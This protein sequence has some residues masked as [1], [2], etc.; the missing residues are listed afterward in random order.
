MTAQEIIMKEYGQSK[1]FVTPRIEGY[2]T[3]RS[4]S[5]EIVYEVSSGT[6]VNGGVLYGLSIVSYDHET[7]KTARMTN[8]SRCF[9]SMKYMENY[10]SR[11]KKEVI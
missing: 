11:L 3:I 6:N 1:N 4:C 9:R 5:P 7:G 10:I 2:G 8:L